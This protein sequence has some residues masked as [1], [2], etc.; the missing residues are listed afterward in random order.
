M[1]I[2]T[3]LLDQIREVPTPPPSSSAPLGQADR[4]PID[5][6]QTRQ[7]LPAQQSVISMGAVRPTRQS[8]P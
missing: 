7:R 6:V 5:A 8:A 4:C 2:K 1:E 3:P